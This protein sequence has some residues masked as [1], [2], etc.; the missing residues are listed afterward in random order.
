MSFN[1]K[2]WPGISI[3]EEDRDLIQSIAQQPGPLVGINA[4][5]ALMIAAAI[6]AKAKAP[7]VAPSQDRRIDTISPGNLNSYNEYKQFI[8]LIYYLTNGGENINKMNDPKVLVENFID[9][10]RRGLKMLKVNYLGSL[11]GSKKM[12][13]QFAELLSTAAKNSKVYHD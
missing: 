1:D 10:A 6:A 13:E 4:K 7:E 9:Y 11:D 2:K 12:E 5:D 8:A 3:Y